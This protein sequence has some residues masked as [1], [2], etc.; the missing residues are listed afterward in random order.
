MLLIADPR[1]K[2]N[3]LINERTPTYETADITVQSKKYGT[4]SLMVA[5]LIKLLSTAGI[6]EQRND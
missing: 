1:K 3:E 4:H 5:K 2:L 6:L